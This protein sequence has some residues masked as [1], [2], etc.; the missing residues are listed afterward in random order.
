MSAALARL[1]RWWRRPAPPVDVPAPR[2]NFT[3]GEFQ[4][5]LARLQGR[6]AA[7]TDFDLAVLAAA[8]KGLGEMAMEARRRATHSITRRQRS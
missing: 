2:V 5:A 7:L 4:L 1:A 6:P 8:D 3:P